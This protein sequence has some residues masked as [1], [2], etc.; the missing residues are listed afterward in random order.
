MEASG[1]VD[2]QGS[3]AGADQAFAECRYEGERDT[4]TIGS[5]RVEG[6]SMQDSVDAGVEDGINTAYAQTELMR[7]CMAARGYRPA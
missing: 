5:Q 3:A 2:S 1:W 7:S 4:A 6:D